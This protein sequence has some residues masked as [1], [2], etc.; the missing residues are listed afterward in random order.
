MGRRTNGDNHNKRPKFTASTKSLIATL[1]ISVGSAGGL[2][3]CNSSVAAK[4]GEPDPN[5]NP[6]SNTSPLPSTLYQG[7]QGL[8]K[9][10]LKFIEDAQAQGLDVVP[11]LTNPGLEIRIASLDSY[12]SSVIGL[13]QT[14]GGVRRV[15]F[16]PDFWNQVSETQ[17][18]LLAHHEFGHC[19][20]FRGHRTTVLTSGV[21][22][23]IMYPSIFSSSTYTNNY[24]Y[25]QAELFGQALTRQSTGLAATDSGPFTEGDPVDR[26]IPTTH[27]CQ[28]DEEDS[29]TEPPSEPSTPP[30]AEGV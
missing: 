16:D 17:R 14:G 29:G 25:Y 15:T 3:A 13:C 23:S 19:M 20:L 26:D 10:V 12:G 5:T 18:E 6:N 30:A 28:P 1:V 8:E 27:V 11:E 21:P 9:Y 4:G 2:Q 24:D 22:A 7:P